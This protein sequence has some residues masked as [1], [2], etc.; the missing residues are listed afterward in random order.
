LYDGVSMLTVLRNRNFMLLWS[1]GLISMMGTWMLLAALPFYLYQVTG[2]AL[3]SAALFMV[4]MVPGALLSSVAGVFVDRWDRRRVLVVCNLIAAA[5]IP[6]MLVTDAY[7]AIWVVYVVVVLESTVTQFIMPAEKALLPT[8]VGEEHLLAANSL[9]A[10]NDNLARVVGA[11]LGGVLLGTVCFRNVVIIDAASYAAA[12]ML[13]TLVGVAPAAARMAKAAQSRWRQVREEWIA[14]L[15]LVAHSGLL[16]NLFIVVGVG[17]LG[18]AILSALLAPFAEHVAGFSATDYGWVLAARG[19]GGLFGGLLIAKVG[20][21]VP[22][23]VLL[24][25]GLAGTGLFILPMVL[26]PRL[27]VVLAL[28]VAAGPVFMAWLICMQTVVLKRT[29][30][31]YRG[32]VFGAYG[33]VST[34]LMFVG[35]GLGG[36][37]ADTLGIKWLLIAAAAIYVLAGALAWPLLRRRLGEGEMEATFS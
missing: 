36:S 3:A 27:P 26:V 4:F 11:A 31:S 37:L 35:S 15:R 30:D 24:S 28:M 23:A 14:G 29:E 25:G 7:G 2:S 17:L 8:L 10:L 34:I 33:T 18:D 6:W 1:A 32:R 13:I 21:R 19:V 9:N 16:R 22:P 20:R 5:L 12:A